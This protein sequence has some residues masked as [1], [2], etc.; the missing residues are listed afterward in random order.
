[1]LATHRAYRLVQEVFVGLV[2]DLMYSQLFV[3]WT[4]TLYQYRYAPRIHTDT[5]V[6][7]WLRVITHTNT[8]TNKDTS[9]DIHTDTD[10]DTY[11]KILSDT[12]DF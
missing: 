10:T 6:N 11:L 9:L 1:M 2:W 5:D 8:N 7:T 4:D 3:C 12:V